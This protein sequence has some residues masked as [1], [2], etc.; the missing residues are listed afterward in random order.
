MLFEEF[1]LV[2]GCG[3]APD[4][5]YNGLSVCGNF[6]NLGCVAGQDFSAVGVFCDVGL[7]IKALSA[8]ESAIKLIGEIHSI[9][10]F[11]YSK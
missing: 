7:A 8:V 3:V 4:A 10:S 11:L 6:C 1:F 9:I 2:S 5:I